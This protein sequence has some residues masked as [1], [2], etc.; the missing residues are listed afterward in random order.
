[1]RKLMTLGISISMAIALGARAQNPSSKVHVHPTPSDLSNALATIDVVFSR[2]ADPLYSVSPV[3]LQADAAEGQQTLLRGVQGVAHQWAGILTVSNGREM[4]HASDLFF[5]YTEVLDIDSYIDSV[6][7]ED[8]LR[9]KPANV[10]KAA[11]ALVNARTEL[12]PAIET[13]KYGV[14][15]RIDAEEAQCLSRRPK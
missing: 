4:P 14:A 11:T 8:R 15:D 12:V 9:N 3:L 10:I 7:T 6:A 2:I 5:V 13:V 1:M